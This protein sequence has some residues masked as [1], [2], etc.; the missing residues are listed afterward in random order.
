[1][2]CRTRGQLGIVGIFK[3]RAAGP[4][5]SFLS[6]FSMGKNDWHQDA[7]LTSHSTTYCASFAE[8]IRFLAFFAG[9]TGRFQNHMRNG[10][11]PKN[12][13][14]RLVNFA[15]INVFSF[16]KPLSVIY[17]SIEEGSSFPEQFPSSNKSKFSPSYS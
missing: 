13:V 3:T 15:K 10:K 12:G 6:V 2:E 1:M 17:I 7:Q 16:R 8:K 9:S 4:V 11:L 14:Y 5:I